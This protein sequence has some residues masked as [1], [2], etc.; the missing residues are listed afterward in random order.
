MPYLPTRRPRGLTALLRPVR[1]IHAQS[2]SPFFTKLPLEIRL[3]IY[4]SLFGS[5]TV[6]PEIYF[7]YRD[8]EWANIH[9]FGPSWR[10]FFQKPKKCVRWCICYR[11]PHREFWNDQC[12]RR[13][14]NYEY[15]L[16][17]SMLIS[18]RQA[19]VFLLS[20]KLIRRARNWIGG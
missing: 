10:R 9:Y 20:E 6:H 16:E 1:R 2:K 3:L 15:T 11:F 19:W 18:C 12:V 7:A 13:V 17:I 14:K 4:Q 8:N 5:R